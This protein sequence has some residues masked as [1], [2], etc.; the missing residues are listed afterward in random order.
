[1]VGGED[2]MAER[3]DRVSWLS[4]ELRAREDE[5]SGLPAVEVVDPLDL[6][7]LFAEMERT[8]V[9]SEIDRLKAELRDIE[10]GSLHFRLTGR[11]VHDATIEADA[12]G[13]LARDLDQVG[14]TIGTDLLVGVSSPGSYIVEVL[15]APQREMFDEPF[16]ATADFLIDAFGMAH[17]PALDARVVDF[18]AE[19]DAEVMTA[20]TRLVKHLVEHE[21]NVDLSAESGGRTRRRRLEREAANALLRSLN[22]VTESTTTLNVQGRF[23]GAIEDSGRFEIANGEQTLR[24]HV[25][26]AVRPQ[27]VGLSIGDAVSAEIDEIVSRKNTGKTRPRLRLR[28]IRAARGPSRA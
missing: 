3:R 6:S 17:K 5:L 25:P 16:A 18:A 7:T 19:R 22:D 24:G 10:V 20:L 26:K 21:V 1:M 15:P 13:D 8:R 4:E 28:A 27:L 9:A 2:L 14:R 11:P 12:L 23:G